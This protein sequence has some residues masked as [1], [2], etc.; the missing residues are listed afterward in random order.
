MPPLPATDVI[1]QPTGNACRDDVLGIRPEPFQ[2]SWVK[3]GKPSVGFSHEDI[4][5]TAT[6]LPPSLPTHLRTWGLVLSGHVLY[7]IS[8]APSSTDFPPSSCR[9]LAPN[10]TTF[11]G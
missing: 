6:S 7:L 9:L 4:H 8:K 1:V 2:V 10:K 11:W 3:E 5:F